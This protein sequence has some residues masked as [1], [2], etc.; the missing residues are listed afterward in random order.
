MITYTVNGLDKFLSDIN[1]KP[2]IVKRA[3]DTELSLSASRIEK[4]AKQNANDKFIK[5]YATGKTKNSIFKAKI[6]SM[7][8]KITSPTNYSIYLEKGTRKMSAVSFMK[9]ALDKEKPVLMSRLKRI[10]G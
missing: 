3:V 2:K 4:G 1:S 7:E 8:F 5:G 9:P 10:I 6:G